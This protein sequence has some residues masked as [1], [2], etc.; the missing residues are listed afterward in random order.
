MK[1]SLCGNWGGEAN[2]I[3][4]IARKRMKYSSMV[5]LLQKI[6][7]LP[8]SKRRELEKVQERAT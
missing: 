2:S 5:L 4:G 1:T 8:I 7:R 3:L 6:M